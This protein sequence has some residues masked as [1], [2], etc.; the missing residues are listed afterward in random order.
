MLLKRNR[1]LAVSMLAVPLLISTAALA[2]DLSNAIKLCDA[3]PR[4]PMV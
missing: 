4:A 2:D 3:N 1:R